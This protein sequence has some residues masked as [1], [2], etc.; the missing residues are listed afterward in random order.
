MLNIYR[1][2]GQPMSEAEG[3]ALPDEIIWMDL[4]DPTEDE[5]KLVERRAG[6]RMP[7]REAL[8]EIEES[9]RLV[10]ENGHLY[11]STPVIGNNTLEEAVLSPLGFVLGPKVLVTIRYAALPTFDTVAERIRTDPT[12]DCGVGVFVALLEAIID[13]G[14]DALERLGAAIDAVSRSVFRGKVSN[15]KNPSKETA[16]L[17]ETLSRVGDLGERLSK[18]RDVLLG[19]GRVATFTGDIGHEWLQSEFR[20]RLK[21]VSKDVRSLSDYETHLSDKIQFLLDAVLGYITIEQNDIF[22]VLTIASVVGVPPT[23]IAGIWGMNFKFMPELSWNWGYPMAWGAIIL[24]A[25]LPLFWFWR[26]GWF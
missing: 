1:D 26:R 4:F 7:S 11:L 9:S 8:S 15:L 21:A 6:I 25:L 20:E 16:S 2:T 14:A 5:S 13:R 19:V 22:K 24:S 17:R 3:C 10:K 18:A 12:L 23:L